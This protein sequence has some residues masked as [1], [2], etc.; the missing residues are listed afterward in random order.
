VRLGVQ[1]ADP[2]PALQEDGVHHPPLGKPA[3]PQRAVLDDPLPAHEDG[4]RA[5]AV[6][7][8]D[9]GPALGDEAAHRQE[10]VA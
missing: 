1:I 3:K 4:V 6:G 2:H 8:D 7:L 9:V 5:S 10:L